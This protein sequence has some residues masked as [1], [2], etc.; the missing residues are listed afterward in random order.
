[1]QGF[2]STNTKANLIL[3][4]ESLND[5]VQKWSKYDP[6]A[7]GFIKI[8]D[9]QKMIV[10]VKPPLGIA[11]DTSEEEK[12]RYIDALQLATFDRISKYNFHDVLNN[13]TRQLLVQAKIK[14][15]TRALDFEAREEKMRQFLRELNFDNTKEEIAAVQELEK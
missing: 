5:F 7:T 12:L 14:L 15:T 8:E 2:N 11:E 9:F 1:M 10:E 3:K 4:E 13:I 6:L